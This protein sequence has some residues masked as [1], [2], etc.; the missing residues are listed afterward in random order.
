M[1]CYE[2]DNENSYSKQNLRLLV[3]QTSENSC[4]KKN[5]KKKK[6]KKKKLTVADPTGR[7]VKGVGLRPLACCVCG[8]ESRLGHEYLSC[9]YVV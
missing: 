7:P 9:V 2:R 3:D 4:K 5:K 8:V 6:K 1:E